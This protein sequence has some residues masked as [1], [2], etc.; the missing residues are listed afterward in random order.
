MKAGIPPPLTGQDFFLPAH[1][2][3]AGA[4]DLVTHEGL[5]EDFAGNKG[6]IVLRSAELQ[7][8]A[9]RPGENRADREIGAPRLRGRE[10]LFASA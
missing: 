5:Q 9:V 8:G 4:V 3:V 2:T 6:G 7:F 10:F 1:E